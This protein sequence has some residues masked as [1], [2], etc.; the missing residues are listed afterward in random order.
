MLQRVTQLIDS[1]SGLLEV[2]AQLVLRRV[3]Q[4][5]S[6][7]L[8]RVASGAVIALGAIAVLAAITIVIAR[9]LGTP[10]ALAIVGGFVLIAGAVMLW[11]G[12]ARTATDSS[13]RLSDAE[14]KLESQ[15]RLREIH[16]LATPGS[17]DDDA[18]PANDGGLFSSPLLKSIL[19][20][21]DTLAG[22]AFAVVGL[23]GPGQTLRL[24]GKVASLITIATSVVKAVQDVRSP[25]DTT[26]NSP[27]P[28]AQR[29]S[30]H[31]PANGSPVPPPEQTR[32]DPLTY[33]S[34]GNGRTRAAASSS[35]P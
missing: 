14:L 35:P 26:S 19:Q 12:R 21:P 34:T 7:F 8:L 11:M 23:L 18:R 17:G 22:A 24:L 20:R 28:N 27:T 10:E 15:R 1:T 3:E 31:G 2:Q 4:A 33:R 16:D 13:P 5:A 25:A 32:Q 29:S 30:T 9:A 6:S